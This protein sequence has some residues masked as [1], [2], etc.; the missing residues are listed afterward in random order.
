MKVVGDASGSTFPPKKLRE[1]YHAGASKP[2]TI[3]SVPPT[4]DD[5]PTASV[6]GPN[7]QTCPPSLRS[8]TK[9]VPVTIFAVTT[10]VIADASIVLPHR[11]RVVSENLEIV[12]DSTSAGGFNADA[13]GTLKLNESVNSSDSFYASQDLDSDTLHCIYVPKW[14]VL[15]DSVLDDPY[16]C[17]DLTD[18]LAP[19]TLFAQL[20]AMDYDQLYSEFNVGA[21]RQLCLERDVE[22]VHLKSLLSLKEAEAAD[23]IRLRSQLTIVEAADA[24][25]GGELSDLKEKNF[26]H[27]GERDVMSEKIATLE[28]ANVAKEAELASLSSQVAKLTFDLSSFQLSSDELDSKVASLESERGC[29]ISKYSLESAFELFRERIEALQD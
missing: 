15:N 8:P 5:G 12:A 3:V 14:N 17:R 27:E 29:L 24:A 13:A 16:A 22:I 1:D 4:L 23:A 28:S 10:T 2:P 25:K 20:G 6:S 19:P 21:A 11:V 7:L 9:D 26:E 18:R